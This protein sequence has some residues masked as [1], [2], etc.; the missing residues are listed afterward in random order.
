MATNCSKGLTSPC[1]SHSLHHCLEPQDTQDPL[2][3]VRQHIESHFST[4]VGQSA[5]QEVRV[6]H[7]PLWSD[8]ACGCRLIAERKYGD[9][10]HTVGYQGLRPFQSE[11][12]PVG[13]TS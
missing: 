8:G 10:L 1:Q 4:Y 11:P 13:R 5:R 12:A 7:R 3:V 6:A 9:T 2:E